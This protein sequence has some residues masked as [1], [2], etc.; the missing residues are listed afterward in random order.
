MYV[1]MECRVKTIEIAHT[2]VYTE[3]III[4]CHNARYAPN[5]I[6]T[7]IIHLYI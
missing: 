2:H 4:L 5:V 3:I 7:R 1:Y 6:Y